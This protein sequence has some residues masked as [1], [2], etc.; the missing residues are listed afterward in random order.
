MWENIIK[1]FLSPSLPHSIYTT[2]YTRFL[3]LTMSKLKWILK[4]LEVENEPGLSNAQLMLTN[5]DLRPGT[6]TYNPPDCTKV[7]TDFPSGP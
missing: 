7:V 4:K 3:Y 2:E 5:S 1:V 6:Y